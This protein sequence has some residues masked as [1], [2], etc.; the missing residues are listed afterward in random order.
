M[1][2]PMLPIDRFL[3]PDSEVQEIVANDP[4][5]Q[6]S[7]ERTA[8]A[9]KTGSK[10][11]EFEV[12][13]LDAFTSV[14]LPWPPAWEAEPELAAK[15]V[16]YPKR[17]REVIYYYTHLPRAPVDTM[18]ETCHDINM[19]LAWHTE[20]EE[21]CVCITCSSI[22]YLRRRQREVLGKEMLAIQGF[23]FDVQNNSKPGCSGATTFTHR[24]NVDLV[25]NAFHG[26]VGVAALIS[27]IIAYPWPAEVD[28]PASEVINDSDGD[29]Y[30]GSSG[31]LGSDIWE[32][33]F[34]KD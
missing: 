3:L 25:G 1:Q 21:K 7:C 24:Q 10:P 27:V 12:N 17:A 29:D 32:N 33:V 34:C 23:S 18:K 30:A 9:A 28:I 22:L 11:A 5:F 19:N 6:P 4:W 26:F 13:H 2:I 14:G 20:A 31:S 8:K 16:C 15:V